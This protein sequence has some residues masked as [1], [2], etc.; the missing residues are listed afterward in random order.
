MSLRTLSSSKLRAL[1]LFLRILRT[2][3]ITTCVNLNFL[4][5]NSSIKTL[6]N[7]ILYKS[8]ADPV[9]PNLQP[10]NLRHK[11]SSQIAVHPR[12]T[13]KPPNLRS[14]NEGKA[15]YVL[16]LDYGGHQ[17]RGASGITSIQ[18]CIKSFNLPVHIVEPLVSASQFLGLSKE[19]GSK[20]QLN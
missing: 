17:S 19:N 8:T 11:S 6:D 2:L 18:C 20:L 1:F 5:N 14:K 7:S 3:V 12:P 4:N 13:A 15:R 9:Y 10:S 16:T